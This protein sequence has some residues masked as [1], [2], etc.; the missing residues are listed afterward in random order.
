MEKFEKDFL[1]LC[2]GKIKL[3]EKM[4]IDTY[5]SRY[6]NVVHIEK[7]VNSI[8]KKDIDTK[9]IIDNINVRIAG[10][11]TAIRNMGK[12]IFF[13]VIDISGKIQIY[14]NNVTIV[15]SL[16]KDDSGNIV[17]QLNIG[18]I[19]GIDGKLFFTK[20]GELT[21]RAEFIK[22]LSK[23]VRTLPEKWNK[24]IDVETRYRKRY[25]DFISNPE[26]MDIIKKR[27][28]II[29]EI[30]LFLD[31]L[32][33]I[34]VET[35]ILQYTVG[36]AIAKPFETF[37]NALSSGM[38]LRISPEL[39]L[40][41]LLVA[42]FTNIYEIGKNFRNEGIS[43]KHSPEFTTLE[44]YQAYGDC[45]TMMDI[46]EQLIYNIAMKINGTPNVMSY[47]EKI[48]DLTP[49]WIRISYNDLIKSKVGEDWFNIS[50]CDKK[51]RVRKL[52]DFDI[53]DKFSCE[54]DITNEVYSK[55]I[56]HELINPTFV[57]KLPFQLVP[58]AKRCSDDKNLVDVFE[59]EING[60]EIA[61]AYSELN[62]PFEQ[63]QRFINQHI[64]EDV[65]E[66][67]KDF[68]EALEYGMPP[69]GGMGIGI[70]RLVMLITG[71]NSIRDVIPFPQMKSK[72]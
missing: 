8:P 32:N 59:L 64:T 56:E 13:D 42:G 28:K 7:I 15:N 35:P 50:D 49:P 47:N 14:T 18:D 44:I 39:F 25:L 48:I 70:D 46:V 63:M 55:L 72:V 23:S 37:Y 30:R 38:K 12:S 31:K 61:P 11:I 62:D 69:A 6:D 33:F 54:F 2:I 67:D 52:F 60:S 45:R 29:K 40:K 34:E 36:G 68:I 71:I 41:K 9:Q 10:R 53:N 17:K 16:S 19:I 1:D 24:L 20:M 21:I 65:D 5:G 3:W 26:S 27:F 66:I 57:T 51:A 22:I 58:L 4:G 43:K